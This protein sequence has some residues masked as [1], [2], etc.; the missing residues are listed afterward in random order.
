MSERPSEVPRQKERLSVIAVP[1]SHLISSPIKSRHA[2]LIMLC[3][4]I[5][6]P[7]ATST[8]AHYCPVDLALI[9]IC[10]STSAEQVS[11]EQATDAAHICRS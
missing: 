4:F 6:R 11:A 8:A 10:C 3:A 5:F 1:I 7:D 2:F 9:R